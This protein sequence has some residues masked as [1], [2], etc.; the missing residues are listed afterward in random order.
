VFGS[1]AG[2]DENIHWSVKD[3]DGA[4]IESY[5]PLPGIQ[6]NPNIAGDLIT[7]ESNT[8]PGSQ[9]DIWLYDLATNR[10]YQLT[11]TSVSE[12]L[13]DVSTG[14]GGLVRVVWAQPK[15]VYPYD[16]DVYAMS[17][18]Q[19]DITPPT[20]TP[21]V[22]GTLGTDGWYTGDVSLTWSLSDP[23]SVMSSISGCEAVSITQDQAAA[24]YTCSATSRGGMS[25][26]TVTIARDATTPATTV[27]GVTEGAT[28]NLGSVPQ[29][30][31]S[32]TDTLSGLATEATFALTGGDPQ[33]VGD[34]TATCSGALDAA[35]NTADPAVVHYTV[36]N[37]SNTYNFTGFFQPV[38]NW[39]TENTLKAGAGVPIKFTLGGDMGLAILADGSP[40]SKQV[41]CPSSSTVT[42]DAIEETTTSNSGLTYDAVSG[43]YVYVWKTNRTWVNS[44]RVFTILF[45]DGSSQ[46]AL[47]KFS[48]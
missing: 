23:E 21:T 30:G 41:N 43:Q 47:F 22:S 28:Y 10:L 17:F 12:T 42:A 40:T 14:P 1:T 33:G 5:L 37:P 27:T 32:S 34:I 45:A 9:F 3:S 8:T 13:T 29:A 48:K 18:L 46:Q 2:G 35:G 44:C 31:C 16:M 11:D 20:I 36:N 15:Q 7:F 25:S 19:P 4:Y 6:R 38:D 24:D 39:P 26:E